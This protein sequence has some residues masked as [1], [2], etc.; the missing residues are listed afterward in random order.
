MKTRVLKSALLGAG[1]FCGCTVL[2]PTVEVILKLPPL[3]DSFKDR[4]Q[5]GA[6][7]RCLILYENDNGNIC[8]KEIDY[9]Q[10]ASL[11]IFKRENSPVLLYP[12]FSLRPYGGFFTGESILQM[13]WKGGFLVETI[14][15]TDA[16]LR[17]NWNPQ[18]LLERI[19]GN[20]WHNDEN[21]LRSALE[22]RTIN[23]YSIKKKPL[24][25]VVLK[26]VPAGVWINRWP[27]EK[28][29]VPESRI[30]ET[31]LPL[32]YELFLNLETG[33]RLSLYV[34]E[35]GSTPFLITEAE[36]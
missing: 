36:W 33:Q 27:H 25:K 15:K 29:T 1:V 35:N 4:L 14:Y 12:P 13:T 21:A 24:Y 5:N 22:T 7:N 18:P 17:K 34:N 3:P 23:R 2:S 32:G 16:A 20:P 9:T 8:K 28:V 31:E 11:E 30:F 6:D 19:N 26:D 10:T